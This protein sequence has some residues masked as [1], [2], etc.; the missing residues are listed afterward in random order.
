MS[1]FTFPATPFDLETVENSITGSTY[2]WREELSKWVLTRQSKTAITDIIF[3]GDSP[4]DPRGD[5][6]L[7]YSTDTL[8]LYF[9]YEDENGVGAWVPTSA[10]ITMI[11]DLE[12]DVQLALAKAGVAEAAA[13]ANLTTIALLDQ[14]LSDV[15]NSLGK[16]TLEEVLTNGAVADQGIILRSPDALESDADAIILAPTISRIVLAAEKKENFLPTFQ[17]IEEGDKPDERRTA[18]FELDDGRLDINMTEQQDEVHFRFR[19]DEELIL[20]HRS[21]AAGASELFGRLK[22]D[23]GR[24]GNEVVTYDQLKE[25]TGELEEIQQNKEKGQWKVDKPNNGVEDIDREDI[26]VA[27]DAVYEGD[28][29]NLSA[30]GD[31]LSQGMLNVDTVSD[32]NAGL[33]AQIEELFQEYKADKP[34]FKNKYSIEVPG[35]A[36]LGFVTDFFQLDRITTITNQSGT[37]D[38]TLVWNGPLQM[39]NIPLVSVSSFTVYIDKTDHHPPK[40]KYFY[41][42]R[43]ED[44]ADEKEACVAKYMTCVEN[45]NNDPGALA[46]CNRDYEACLSANK[47]G[48]YS[49]LDFETATRLIFNKKDLNDITHS[50]FEVRIGDSVRIT[51]PDTGH[52]I[53]AEIEAIWGQDD[54]NYIRFGVK[55]LSHSGDV[56]KDRICNVAFFKFSDEFVDLSAYVKKTGDEMTGVLHLNAE[57][58][59]FTQGLDKD[60]VITSLNL[61]G[62]NSQS[63]FKVEQGREFI[64]KA[65]GKDVLHVLPDETLQLQHLVDV[66][67]QSPDHSAVPKKICRCQ[68]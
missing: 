67:S 65:A 11:E 54:P 63:I 36:D 38:Y 9:W 58:R 10:P 44:R 68:P 56:V 35:A 23:A 7:W 49:T 21:N 5:Y 51:Q 28:D 53:L 29:F 34:A 19:D 16:V 30:R 43:Y 62:S 31:G 59:Q 57:G 33:R 6:K 66:N 3:E 15:E 52:F 13:N 20:R 22:V 17:L 25:V 32:E 12:A 48:W 64:L 8:E 40:E 39:A 45:S 14:A 60:T 18:E 24:E 41:M 2:Q 55:N 4:P 26:I 47:S 27:E 50:F 61:Q 42:E 1:A 46:Q 37:Q